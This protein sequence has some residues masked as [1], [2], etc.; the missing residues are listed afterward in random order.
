LGKEI[1]A[2]ADCLRRASSGPV[3]RTAGGGNLGPGKSPAADPAAHWAVYRLAAQYRDDGQPW[4]DKEMTTGSA[5]SWK[6][7]FSFPCDVA[8]DLRLA[9]TYALGINLPK[10]DRSASESH[11]SVII[12]CGEILGLARYAETRPEKHT[13]AILREAC[14]DLEH[15]KLLAEACAGVCRRC[16]L[17]MSD[18][19][20][21][22]AA[23]CIQQAL[24]CIKG[25]CGPWSFDSLNIW[26]YGT[27]NRR[28][29]S[30]SAAGRHGLR[31]P[32]LRLKPTDAPSS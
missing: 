11:A 20:Y 27:V 3:F 19:H 5:G 6:D 17:Q 14:G 1:L 25:R 2:I 16:G 24:P 13:L 32:A 12:A 23:V 7:G 4:D 29:Q 9:H 18:A 8:S 22:A 21:R 28:S 30:A 15:L 26:R 10:L 31:F